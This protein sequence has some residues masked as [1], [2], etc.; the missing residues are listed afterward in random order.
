MFLMV[1]NISMVLCTLVS[2]LERIIYCHREVGDG[3]QITITVGNLVVPR[4]AANIAL[5]NNFDVTHR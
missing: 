4:V 1:F 2:W 5:Q 3:N